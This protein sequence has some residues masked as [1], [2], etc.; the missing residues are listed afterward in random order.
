[1]AK[2]RPPVSKSGK[3][4]KVTCITIDDDVRSDLRKLGR[5]NISA[6]VRKAMEIA[7]LHTPDLETRA[8]MLPQQVTGLV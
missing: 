8:P 7:K 2:G 6:G 5:G 1:M 3:A 4:T